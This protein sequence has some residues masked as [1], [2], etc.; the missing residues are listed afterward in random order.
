MSQ[1]CVKTDPNMSQNWAK[2]ETLQKWRHWSK[3]E[4]KLMKSELITGC[5]FI[6]LKSDYFLPKK[7]SIQFPL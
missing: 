4:A 6:F 1:I 7:V 2:K 5:P 3:T